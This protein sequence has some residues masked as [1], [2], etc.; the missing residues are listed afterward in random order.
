MMMNAPNE[1]A[2]LLSAFEAEHLISTLKEL[3]LSD[4]GTPNWMKQHEAIE[5]LNIQAHYNT[6]KMCEEFVA[7]SLVDQEKIQTVV[8]DLLLIDMWKTHVWPKLDR[9]KIN[10]ENM[11]RVYFMLYHES[12]V[13]NLLEIVLYNQTACENLGD[14]VVDLIDYCAR[15]IAALGAWDNSDTTSADGK[16]NAMSNLLDNPSQQLRTHLSTLSIMRHITTHL[17]SMPFSV[18]TRILNKHDLIVALVWVL[19]KTPWERR[20]RSGK[21]WVME[22]FGENAE[23]TAVDEEERQGVVGWAAQAW[24][25]LYTLLLDEECRKQYEFNTHNHTTVL[26]L[27][28]HMTPALL[29]QIP[30]LASLLRHLEELS[31]F[32]SGA[33]SAKPLMGFVEELPSV[34]AKL[35]HNTDLNAV[36]KSAAQMLS[37]PQNG[38]EI[39][40]SFADTYTHPALTT[41]LP[42]TPKCANPTCPNRATHPTATQRCSQCKSEW[43]CS[44]PCQVENWKVHKPVCEMLK[45]GANAASKPPVAAA[46]AAAGPASRIVEIA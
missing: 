19:E 30:P 31:L 23:W 4:V 12:T 16:D 36:I 34:E 46:A 11:L 41:L 39:A 15:K 27:R 24:L 35:L 43:Y 26:K 40:Q 7:V 1:E 18:M 33:P 13:L 9:K 10:G 32:T 38:E 22:R 28:Q 44:R 25:T 5:K 17:S 37:K 45:A 20:R 6:M 21:K 29:D 8:Y 2:P 14:A 42:D 3:K